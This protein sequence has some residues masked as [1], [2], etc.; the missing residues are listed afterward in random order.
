[1]SLPHPWWHILFTT[2]VEYELDHT[3]HV[4]THTYRCSK[5]KTTYRIQ[6]PGSNYPVVTIQK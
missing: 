3:T 1:M 6:E 4:A 5:C 2:F